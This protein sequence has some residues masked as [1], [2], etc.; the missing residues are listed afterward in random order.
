MFA[1]EV[2]LFE[3]V[4][5]DIQQ[6]KFDKSKEDLC[7]VLYKRR[8]KCAFFIIVRKGEERK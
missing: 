8:C 6:M 2:A 1:G 7:Y 5:D 3:S 4:Y